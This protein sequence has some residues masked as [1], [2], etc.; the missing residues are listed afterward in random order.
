MHLST[1]YIAFV[2]YDCYTVITVS[3]SIGKAARLRQEKPIPMILVLHNA[4]Y[5]GLGAKSARGVFQGAK[6]GLVNQNSC[7][8]GLG[9]EIPTCKGIRVL[10]TE[11]HWMEI[12]IYYLENVQAEISMYLG[13]WKRLEILSFIGGYWT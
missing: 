9:D 1:L 7:W 5:M 8:L 3:F 12:W 4:D 2:Y 13:L 6:W 10:S 11:V